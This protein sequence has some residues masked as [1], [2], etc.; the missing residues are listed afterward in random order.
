MSFKKGFDKSIKKLLKDLGHETSE[1]NITLVEKHIRRANIALKRKLVPTKSVKS[2]WRSNRARRLRHI[3][4]ESIL[5]PDDFPADP[6][7]VGTPR[8]RDVKGS[9]ISD[10]VKAVVNH[11][12]LIS[13]GGR[14]GLPIG[15]SSELLRAAQRAGINTSGYYVRKK[16]GK[17]L[18]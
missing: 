16:P 2:P 5:P 17:K 11:N 15:I 4:Y 6:N 18:K 14:R 10:Y 1:R 12:R 9:R 8:R 7:V 3:R 13:S